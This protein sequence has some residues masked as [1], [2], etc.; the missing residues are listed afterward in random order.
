M[1]ILV[2]SG[3]PRSGQ[4]TAALVNAFKE[5][6]ESKGHEINVVEVAKKEIKGCMACEYCHTKG[7][8]KCVIKDGME[9]IYPLYAD[10]DM[11]VLASPI[12]YFTMTAQI[13]AAIQRVYCMDHPTN[14]TQAALLLTS[15]SPGTHNG[16]I[17]EYKG[18][19]AYCNLEDKGI[20]IA[21]GDENQT[22]AKLAEAKAFGASL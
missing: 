6:A 15:A 5:G 11:I 10:C 17:E 20:L 8:G 14:A 9:D 19:C 7:E 16:A 3:S 13:Q 21:V 1:K 12:Y 4:N 18:Y 2:L 22:E